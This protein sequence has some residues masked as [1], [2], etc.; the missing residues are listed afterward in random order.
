MGY[1]P[2]ITAPEMAN[3]PSARHYNTLIEQ[4]ARARSRGDHLAAQQFATAAHEWAMDEHT[5]L[6]RLV[7]AREALAIATRQLETAWDKDRECTTVAELRERHP[8]FGRVITAWERAQQLLR[9]LDAPR[10]HPV[11]K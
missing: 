11:G 2:H 8:E 7:H 6:Q 3:S 5:R 4:S 10:P 9:D 1:L